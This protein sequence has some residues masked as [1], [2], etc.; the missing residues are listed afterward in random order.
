MLKISDHADLILR[1]FA[2]RHQLSDDIIEGLTSAAALQSVG[3]D[4]ALMSSGLAEEQELLELIAQAMQIP[5][6]KKLSSEVLYRDVFDNLGS[7][8]W[9]ER[10]MAPFI[11]DDGDLYVGVS[12]PISDEHINEAA[13]LLHGKFKIA[14][15][16]SQTLR[17]A[18]RGIDES[19][20]PQQQPET[21]SPQLTRSEDGAAAH[22]ID[23]IVA[24]AVA[25]C[26][27]DIH[28][29]AIGNKLKTRF[30]VDGIL[31]A[32]PSHKSIDASTVMARLKLMGGMSVTE[33][34]MP[35]DGSCRINHAGRTIEL[36]LSTLPAYAGESLVCRLLDPKTTKRGWSDLGFPDDM[37]KAFVS[38][39]ERP[40]GLLVISGPTGSGKTTTIYTA[41]RHLNDGT[42]KILT[43]EDPIE[44]SIEG[45][46]QVQVHAA[47][48]LT[49]SKVLRTTLR[50]DPDV[51]MIGEIRDEE[52]A[53]IACRAALVGRLV[54]ATIHASSA[55]LVRE[56][57]IN[58][59]VPE[60]LIDEV[61]LGVLSQR[62]VPVDCKACGGAGCDQ[63]SQTGRSGRQ[64]EVK[65]W[66]AERDITT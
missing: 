39:V 37:A 1:L 11:A 48:G 10:A 35:Q 50:H 57:F 28:L 29:D 15:C 18:I 26:A 43:V 23:I 3:I 66:E 31:R 13:F 63:C 27:S 21:K 9:E 61:L 60:Y 47:L 55:R 16:E 25:L 41:I 59:G 53:E 36:R 51:L 45:V 40:H 17:N 56:R 2:E 8:F 22:A 19:R 24:D 54:M 30:R 42:R 38:L 65:L 20:A 7:E 62:L 6:I 4:H 46:E 52:T 12:L 34:R 14:L 33:R 44:Q 49:F 5:L 32:Q 58:L 64:P